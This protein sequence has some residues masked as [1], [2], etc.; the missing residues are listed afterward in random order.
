MNI[1]KITVIFFSFLSMLSCTK[2]P[3][4]DILI[5]NGKIIDGTGNT[6]S[7][8]DIGINADTIAAIGDLKNKTANQEIDATGLV[9]SPGFI[10]MLSWASAALNTDGR[11]LGDIKQ[12]VTLEVFGEGT[13]MGPTKKVDTVNNTIE[14]ISLNDKLNA[15]VD[16]GVS[17]NIASFIGA[18]TLRIN[19]VGYEDRAPTEEELDSM[20]IMVTQAMEEGAMGIGSSLIYAPAFY[21]ST[22]ELIEISKVAAKYDGLYTS[23]IRSEGNKLLESIDELLRIAKEANIRAEIY[24]LKMSGKDNWHKY[25]AVVAKIDSARKAGLTITA[26]MYSYIAGSTGLDASMPPWVQE[27]GYNKWAERLQ[28]PKIRKKVLEDM[29]KPAIEWESLMQAAGSAEKMILAGFSNDSLRYLTGKTLAEVA[30]MRNT[31]PEETAMDLV[32]Q[33]GSDVSTV[34]FMMSEENVKKQVALPWMS[35]CSDAGSYAAEGD[36][37]KYSTHPRAYGN[38]ARVIGKYTRD[39]KVISLEEAIRKLTFL[40]AT[41]LKLKKRGSLKVGNYA[42]IV[43]FDFDKIEDHATFEKPHQYASGMM[44]VFVNGTQ[45]LKGGEHTNKKPG[46]VVHGPGYRK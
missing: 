33:N 20:K 17:P 19:T 5:Q 2:Q 22:E 27:G 39:E 11:S 23:H 3:D 21:S 29:R 7:I 8:G 4:Y 35:F 32:V 45:V 43:V 18:T 34:Y 15:L 26:N 16:K 24:H 14:W 31:S 36:F 9:V 30:K 42:D 40:P 38:F 12:G 10:N 37:L 28:D 41:N 1:L 46:R 25:D 6:F 44:H 13:S